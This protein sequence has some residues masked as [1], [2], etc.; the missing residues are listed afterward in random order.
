MANFQLNHYKI[1]YL[2]LKN[3]TN[4]RENVFCMAVVCLIRLSVNQVAYRRP[5]MPQLCL[6]RNPAVDVVA[7]NRHLSYF[8]IG[9]YALCM[10]TKTRDAIQ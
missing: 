4:G 6:A 1:K 8:D 7:L 9:K 10:Q 5:D 3:G 2:P